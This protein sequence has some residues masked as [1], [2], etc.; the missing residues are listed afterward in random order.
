MK[1]VVDTN[2]LVSRVMSRKGVPA[3]IFEHWIAGAFELIISTDVWAEYRRVFDYEHILRLH[4]LPSEQVDNILAEL[5]QGSTTV[6]PSESLNVVLADPDDNKFLEC[7][8]AGDA[9]YIVSGDSH[10]LSLQEYRGVRIL[11][12]AVF[13]TL[14]ESG[15]S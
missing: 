14:L 12:P 11:S 6:T 15:Q 8:L 5:K 10:L 3:R 7:A 4:S 1:V 13:L 2:V 9:D